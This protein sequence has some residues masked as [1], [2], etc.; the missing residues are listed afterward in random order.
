MLAQPTT[1]NSTS[2]GGHQLMSTGR[3]LHG[4]FNGEITFREAG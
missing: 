2:T 1:L 4:V 3:A